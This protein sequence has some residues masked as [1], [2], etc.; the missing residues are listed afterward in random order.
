MFDPSSKAEHLME[1]LTALRG[2]T[3]DER[4]AGQIGSGERVFAIVSDGYLI[5]VSTNLLHFERSARKPYL[6]R[7]RSILA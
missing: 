7:C 5:D 4:V 6:K 2:L 3:N 1:K